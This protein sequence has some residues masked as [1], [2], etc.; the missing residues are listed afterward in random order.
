MYTTWSEYGEN[1]TIQTRTS[2]LS[3]HV[4]EMLEILHDIARQ[5]EANDE[6]NNCNT[7]KLTLS[8]KVTSNVLKT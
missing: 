5:H 2:E 7:L 4:D 8:F 1:V 6:T 3:E